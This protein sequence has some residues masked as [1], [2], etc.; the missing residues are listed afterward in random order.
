MVF[1][2]PNLEKNLFPEGL[3]VSTKHSVF[4][5]TK[6]IVLV[7]WDLYTLALPFFAGSCHEESDLRVLASS[8]AEAGAY[9]LHALNVSALEAFDW[10]GSFFLTSKTKRLP[11][12]Y[13][14]YNCRKML[15][16]VLAT[17]L[18]SEFAHPSYGSKWF[19]QKKQVHRGWWIW[20]KIVKRGPVRPSRRD[21][22]GWENN[23]SHELDRCL[24][25]LG[26]QAL[27]QI[28]SKILRYLFS[29]ANKYLRIF[30]CAIACETRFDKRKKSQVAFVEVSLRIT[31]VD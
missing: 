28:S 11:G 18:L 9:Y 14:Y 17:F 12:L 26:V 23:A 16:L 27:Y 7:S 13:I 24:C 10:Y 8:R 2:V 31:Y 5:A 22:S 30:I 19:F 25:R 20:K 1:S 21:N 3:R 6:N 15:L 29:C 4:R